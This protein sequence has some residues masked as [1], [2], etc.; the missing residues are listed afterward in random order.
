MI[1]RLST[2][3]KKFDTIYFITANNISDILIFVRSINIIVKDIPK[4][5]IIVGIQKLLTTTSESNVPIVYETN[6]TNIPNFYHLDFSSKIFPLTFKYKKSTSE[7]EKNLGCSFSKY[8]NKP[9]L[10]LCFYTRSEDQEE[11]SLKEITDE[12][13]IKDEY[14]LYN[15]KIQ[16]VKIEDKIIFNG[17][18]SYIYLYYPQILH[19]SEKNDTKSIYYYIN[20]ANYLTGLTYD[21]NKMVI[22][23]MNVQ[24]KPELMKIILKYAKD[25]IV[26]IQNIIISNKIIVI[27]YQLA[28][29]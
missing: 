20:S 2:L 23:I 10:L 26:I 12:I 14:F 27:I 24:V 11:L 8:D 17:K 4:Q 13:E 1:S 15:Y 21:E 22:V 25:L 16:P 5:D 28:I 29:M 19:F 6:I 18:G 3:P 9:L 7:G